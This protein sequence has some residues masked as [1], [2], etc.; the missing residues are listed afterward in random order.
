MIGAHRWRRGGRRVRLA[1]VLGIATLMV[2]PGIVV[3]SFPEQPIGSALARYWQH[4]VGR[5]A[6]LSPPPIRWPALGPPRWADGPSDHAVFSQDNREVRLL[7]FDSGARN[8]LATG[9]TADRQVFV[10]SRARGGAN[11]AGRLLLASA[12]NGHPGNGDSSHPSLDGGTRARPHCAVFESRAINFDPRD[13]SPDLDIYLRD[14]RRRRPVLISVGIAASASHAVVDGACRTVTF[15][16]AGQ[17]WLARTGGGRPWRISTGTDPDQQTNGRGVAYV[18]RGQIWYR[19]FTVSNSDLRLGRE[20]LVSANRHGRPANG[21]SAEPALDDVGNYVAFSSSATNLCDRRCHGTS[22]D[23]NGRVPDVFRRTLSR[24]APTHDVMEMVSFSARSRLQLNAAS[25]SPQISAAG[26]NVI[27]TTDAT[28]IRRASPGYGVRNPS[29]A[30]MSWSFPPARGYG[31]LSMI[32]RAGCYQI[33]LAAQS[34]PSL[35][36][37][38]NYVA[39]TSTTSEFCVPGGPYFDGERACPATSDVFIHYMGPSPHG[40]PLG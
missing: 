36:S 18:R 1:A 3:A 24:Q 10:V 38:G 22:G 2:G 4:P 5:T 23:A 8:L 37:R 21:T 9:S 14:L 19:R 20:R 12:T 15:A 16:A 35:S 29:S 34:D 26:E 40:E 32:T 7:A 30:V 6:L 27:F 25:G 39:Y 33:C 31:N 28:N 13:R 17:I 11:L